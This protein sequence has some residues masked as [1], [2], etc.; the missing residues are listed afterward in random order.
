LGLVLLPLAHPRFWCHYRSFVEFGASI[1]CRVHLEWLLCWVYSKSRA[2]QI[3]FLD[4]K[5]VSS[6]FLSGPI[7][8]FLGNLKKC[9]IYRHKWFGPKLRLL[10]GYF[11][12]WQLPVIQSDREW[13]SSKVRPRWHDPDEA[14]RVRTTTYPIQENPDGP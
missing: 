13:V 4:L 1:S 2:L 3:W 7:Q 6:V 10:C 14:T 5:F 9:S 8:Y 11:Y 12:E